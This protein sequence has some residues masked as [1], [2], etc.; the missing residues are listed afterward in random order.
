MAQ[1]SAKQ[2][3][4]TQAVIAFDGGLNRADMFVFSY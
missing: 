4:V 2:S 1:S 3:R